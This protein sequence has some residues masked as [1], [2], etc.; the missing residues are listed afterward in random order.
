MLHALEEDEVYIS[1]Q[2][3]CSVGDYSKAVYAV[4]N[5]KTKASHSMRVSIS[6]KSTKEDIDNFINSLA[7]N[8]ERL[9]I[10]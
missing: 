9:K 4:T 10:K 5:S 6:Y 1:T 2:T 3:A 7:K 8:L